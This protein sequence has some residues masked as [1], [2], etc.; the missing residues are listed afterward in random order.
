M[1]QQPVPQEPAPDS[2]T[3]I[4]RDPFATPSTAGDTLTG[5]TSQDVYGGIGKP[6]G[7][8]TSKEIHHDGKAHRKRSLQG[9]DQYGTAD[10][11]RR[12][13]ATNPWPETED[14]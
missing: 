5:V 10:R 11:L 14:Q 4:D 6:W 1:H 3:V 12:S 9:T 7:G 2:R 13:D 8:M